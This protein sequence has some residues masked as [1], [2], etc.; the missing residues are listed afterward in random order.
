MPFKL[1]QGKGIIEKTIK[2]NNIKVGQS[3]SPRLYNTVLLR[4]Q[5]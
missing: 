1:S 3:L 2:I 5:I 4:T